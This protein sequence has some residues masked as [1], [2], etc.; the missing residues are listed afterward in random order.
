MK[1]A[2]AETSIY[3]SI[4]PTTKLSCPDS[5]CPFDLWYSNFLAS[6][7]SKSASDIPIYSPL[8]AILKKYP[9]Y[10]PW[11]FPL[12]LT[13]LFPL[14]NLLYFKSLFLA[15]NSQLAYTLSNSKGYSRVVVKLPQLKPAHILLRNLSDPYTKIYFQKQNKSVLRCNWSLHSEKI[16]SLGICTSKPESLTATDSSP[17]SCGTPAR[18]LGILA[19]VLFLRISL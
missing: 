4:R 14:K 17:A 19:P 11:N 3:F 8:V 10:Y 13:A 18:E 2:T 9:R 7:S 12:F 16:F 15:P 5:A 1:L 6:S